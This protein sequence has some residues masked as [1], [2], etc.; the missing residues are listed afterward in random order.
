MSGKS[1]ERANVVTAIARSLPERACG[2]VVP[3]WSKSIIVCPPT[4]SVSAWALPL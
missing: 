2:P 4:T 1:G 3:I